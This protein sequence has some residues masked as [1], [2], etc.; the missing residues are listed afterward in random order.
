M[1]H[2]LCIL[3]VLEAVCTIAGALMFGKPGAV[4]G[5]FLGFGAVVAMVLLMGVD[6]G[7]SSG[8]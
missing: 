7:E 8:E 6:Q 1:K 3:L 2:L 4:A 5:A